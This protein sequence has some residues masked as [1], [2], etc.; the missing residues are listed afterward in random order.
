MPAHVSAVQY[1]STWSMV[2]PASAMA[3]DVLPRAKLPHS[4][5]STGSADGVGFSSTDTFFPKRQIVIPRY[6]L[7]YK[8]MLVY[9]SYVNTV[10]PFQ[11]VLNVLKN[12]NLFLKILF[13]CC[14]ILTGSTHT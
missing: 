3:S 9:H 10:L 11:C 2:V 8:Y 5:D 1:I 12:H 7:A 14:F 13:F 6:F 4:T